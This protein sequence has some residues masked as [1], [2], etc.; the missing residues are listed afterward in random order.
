M[1]A[2]KITPGDWDALLVTFAAELTNAAYRVVLQQG[3]AGSWVDLELDLWKVLAERVQEW[4][5]AIAT[6]RM[7][8]A[9]HTTAATF[10]ED[11]PYA[12]RK[13]HSHRRPGRPS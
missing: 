2:D 5:A 12:N 9:L 10:R 6:G 11:S 4:G 3:M 8:G 13:N 1:N 7:A